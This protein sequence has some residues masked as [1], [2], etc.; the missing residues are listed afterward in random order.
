MLR[1]VVGLLVCLLFGLVLVWVFMVEVWQVYDV[2]VCVVCL[3][4]SGLCQV[5]VVGQ[6]LFFDDEVGYLVLFLQGCYLQLYMQ[7]CQGCELCL[8][9]C[10]IGKVSV[11]EVDVLFKF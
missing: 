11:S 5:Y 3:K 9:W 8:Y 7:G 1:V 10:V 2:M 4:V 6:V